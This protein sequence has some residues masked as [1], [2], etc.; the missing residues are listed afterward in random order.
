[1]VSRIHV[2]HMAEIAKASSFPPTALREMVS[3]Q[4]GSIVSRMLI[5]K[6]SGTVTLFAFDEGESLSEHSAPYDALLWVLEGQAE[7]VIGGAPY[8]LEG[9][10][11]VH[12]PARVPHAVKAITPFKMML[13]MIHE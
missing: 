6:S 3:Y 11:M 12:L 4:K 13:I 9:D 10:Q 7:V 5:N 1:M 2:P 8:S